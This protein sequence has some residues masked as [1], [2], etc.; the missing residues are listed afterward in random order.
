[1]DRGDD[2]DTVKLSELI[3]GRH[4]RGK[5]F[6]LFLFLKSLRMFVLVDLLLSLVSFGFQNFSFI[7]EFVLQL[8]LLEVPYMLYNSYLV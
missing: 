8:F 6:F 5:Y 7:H 4:F 1:M 2:T 3:Y